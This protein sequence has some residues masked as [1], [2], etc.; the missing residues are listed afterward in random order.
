MA[1]PDKKAELIKTSTE[2]VKEHPFYDQTLS[3]I[4][5]F[6]TAT[7][8]KRFE[9]P[10][11]VVDQNPN[12]QELLNFI[13]SLHTG[14]KFEE[15][16]DE[17]T[18]KSEGKI[19][20][21]ADYEHINKIA[22]DP[23]TKEL[24]LHYETPEE[25]GKV[26]L[27]IAIAPGEKLYEAIF[28]SPIKQAT[29][30]I[31]EASPGPAKDLMDE[32]ERRKEGT[33][34]DLAKAS[35][36]PATDG[37][38]T[39]P[40]EI[41]AGK[42]HEP[43]LKKVEPI[44]EETAE[45]YREVLRASTIGQVRYT[46]RLL[47]KEKEGEGAKQKH[48]G[49]VEET[50]RRLR[51]YT[52]VINMRGQKWYKLNYERMGKDQDGLSHEMNVGLG[53]VLIA[54]PNIK[55]LEVIRIDGERIIATRGVIPHG[56][57]AGRLGYM[58]E[59]GDYVATFT[60]DMFRVMSDEDLDEANYLAA[61]ATEDGHRGTHEKRFKRDLTSY[62]AAGSNYETYDDKDVASY[63]ASRET[64]EAKLKPAEVSKIPETERTETIPPKPAGAKR[65]VIFG[66]TNGSAGTEGQKHLKALQAQLPN[67]SADFVIGVGDYIAAGSKDVSADQY[68][69]LAAKVKEEFK[70]FG[71]TPF[72]L[73]LGNHDKNLAG[74]SDNL[75]ET[76]KKTL[77]EKFNYEESPQKE[78]YSYKLGNA[79]F[80]V[81]NT[82]NTSISDD[83]LGFFSKKSAESEGAVYLINHVP[84]FQ[85]AHGAGL[86]EDGSQEVTNFD[87][88]QEIARKNIEDKG[89][90]FYVIGGHDHF[91]SVIGNFLN[92]GGLGSAYWGLDGKLKSEP[93]AA[94]VDMDEDGKIL[95]VYFRSARSKFENPLP[96][97]QHALAWGKET[98]LQEHIPTFEVNSHK[99]DKIIAKLDRH[100]PGHGKKIMDYSIRICK[101]FNFSVSALWAMV[102]VESNYSPFALNDSSEATGLLQFLNGSWNGMKKLWQ[103]GKAHPEWN[104]D[105]KPDHK[106]FKPS[107]YNPYASI[108]ATVMNMS[109]TRGRLKSKGVIDI[110]K[111]SPAEQAEMFYLRHHEGEAGMRCYLNF[112]KR[113]KASGYSEP[114]QVSTLYKTDKEKF[115]QVFGDTLHKSQK[116]RIETNRQRKGK[117][118][119]GIDSFLNVYFRLSKNIGRDAA[120]EISFEEKK[121]APPAEPERV[122]EGNE[123]PKKKFKRDEIAFLGDSSAQNQWVHGMKGLLPRD[124]YFGQKSIKTEQVEATVR[125]NPELVKGVKLIYIKIGGN[126]YWRGLE[127]FQKG[128]RSLVAEIR[129]HNRDA[130]IVIPEIA[131]FNPNNQKKPTAKQIAQKEQVNSWIAA[132]GD[133]LF[134]P[135]RYLSRIND[136]NNPGYYKP[137]FSKEDRP[138][139]KTDYIHLNGKG[140]TTINLA[141]L[142]QFV[143]KDPQVEDYIRRYS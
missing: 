19:Q 69:E 90:P 113:M 109:A 132:G 60:G 93:S 64:V 82:G 141:F 73:A 71:E 44:N 18:G 8:E 63:K 20:I 1:P 140:Y 98:K 33:R 88:V 105:F 27:N 86:P 87:K 7:K 91:H 107:R 17:E 65:L 40:P 106:G 35:E 3:F 80:V 62:K 43:Y 92:P 118:I 21:D 14:E 76:F 89:R 16:I 32:T 103:A 22:I 6:L 41:E 72:A 66:D 122:S 102:K 12:I 142:E 130:T 136:P 134:K 125:D 84:P 78:A 31:R 81:F 133:G 139:K 95:N 126:E 70:G 108:Y 49:F 56:K 48:E 68:K 128:M 50:V 77:E 99:A 115:Y 137:Q 123:S 143:E 124:K 28:W 26:T 111:L 85:H 55:K 39:P 120:D 9:A 51:S 119:W 53:D 129:K 52:D 79:T 127:R 117:T 101:Q 67:W 121:T 100:I 38:L 46:T 104:E 97:L 37:L 15:V 96:E 30:A 138:G 4:G 24:I 135:L 61:V 42:L 5:E 116:K 11:V 83:Q 57:H 10:H 58:D 75:K 114:S 25:P 23:D 45:S 110:E 36:Q 54:S 131:S 47:N 94:V 29:D 13:K 74:D 2:K 112:M 59:N 34:K